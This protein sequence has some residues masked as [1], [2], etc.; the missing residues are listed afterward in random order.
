MKGGSLVVVLA[1]AVVLGLAGVARAEEAKE[2]DAA[3]APPA[4]TE[5]MET[6]S[7]ADEKQPVTAGGQ[8][9][10]AAR[11]NGVAI[12]MDTV[13]KMANQLNAQMAHSHTNGGG[14]D[15]QAIQK[16]AL[17]RA[18]LQELAYQRALAVGIKVGH[19]DIDDAIIKIKAKVGGEEGYKNSLAREKMTEETLRVEVA[20]GL[21]LQ[22]IYAREVLEKVSVPE[23]KLKEEYEKNKGQFLQPEKVSIIDVVIFSDASDKGAEDKVKDILKKIKDN[24]NDPL[25]LVQDGTFAVREYTEDKNTD[26]ALVRAAKK[27]KVGEISGAITARDSLHIIKLKE[28]VPEKQFTFDEVKGMIEAKLKSDAQTQRM[29][30]WTAELKKDAKIEILEKPK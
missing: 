13:S 4:N 6:T 19:K 27:L 16:E 21:A 10:V 17:D 30:E 20:R 24:D 23:D 29:K 28:Y 1:L 3:A 8:D 15:V 11:V 9:I 2:K 5:K 26:K 22:R 7:H 25:K 12:T 18:I 14:P